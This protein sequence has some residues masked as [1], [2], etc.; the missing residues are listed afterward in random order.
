LLTI[1]FAPLLVRRFWHHH[2]GK[3]AFIWAT[4]TLAPLAALRDVDTAVAALFHA[5]LAD[6]LGFIAVLFALYVVAGGILITGTLRGTPLLNTALLAFGTPLPGA[7]AT[8]NLSPGGDPIEAAAR[9]FVG[10]HVLDAAG[11]AHGCKRIAV[12]PVPSVGLG[13]AIND[14]LRRAAAPR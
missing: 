4:L 1:A 2:Y 13:H 3:L 5:L 8:F 6:Y 10:L 11:P 14:R 9:L 12:M 7:G